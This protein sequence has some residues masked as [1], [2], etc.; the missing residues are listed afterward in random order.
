M[1]KTVQIRDIDDDV[2]DALV[3]R[4]AELGL[5]VPEYLRRETERLAAR[6]TVHEWLERT[7][8]RPGPSRKLDTL[9]ALDE[10]RGSWPS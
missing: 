9:T 7:R 4:A 1:P 6:L 2:Y 3:R 8:R 5:S 10:L